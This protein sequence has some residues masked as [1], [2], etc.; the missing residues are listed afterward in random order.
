MARLCFY[1][2]FIQ[3]GSFTL[4]QKKPYFPSFRVASR[5]GHF[6]LRGVLSYLMMSESTTRLATGNILIS[7]YKKTPIAALFSHLKDPFKSKLLG[8][9][10]N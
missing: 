10:D 3:A 8:S 6:G 7:G 9:N 1:V 4:Q 5:C 2:G